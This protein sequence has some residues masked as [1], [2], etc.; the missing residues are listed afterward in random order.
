MYMCVRERKRC[1]YV[2]VCVCVC[3]VCVCV[4]VTERDTEE[5][6]EIVMPSKWFAKR[7]LRNLTNVGGERSTCGAVLE[8]A[9]ERNRH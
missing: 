7:T 5:T 8:D 4:C 2:C 6:P 9:A 3:V 1:V